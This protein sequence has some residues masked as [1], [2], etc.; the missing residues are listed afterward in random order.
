MKINFIGSEGQIFTSILL[1][2][3]PLD[4]A[5]FKTEARE[6]IDSGFFN[7]LKWKTMPCSF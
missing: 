6:E 3:I 7:R 4:V 1:L 2:F 5:T